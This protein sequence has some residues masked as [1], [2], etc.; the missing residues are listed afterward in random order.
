MLRSGATITVIAA[1]TAA[2]A[3]LAQVPPTDTELR[4]AFCIGVLDAAIAPDSI[5]IQPMPPM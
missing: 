3:G 4:A 1:M 5:F 2:R